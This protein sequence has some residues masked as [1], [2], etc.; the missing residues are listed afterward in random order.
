MHQ[1][2]HGQVP[3]LVGDAPDVNGPLQQASHNR[4]AARS[5]NQQP[6]GGHRAESHQEADGQTRHQLK[7]GHAADP[8]ERNGQRGHQHKERRQRSFLYVD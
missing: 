5:A 3:A 8:R 7:V 4:H 6:S 1:Y 2:R